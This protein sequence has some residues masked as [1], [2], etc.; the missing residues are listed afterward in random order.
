MNQSVECDFLLLKNNFGHDL[1]FVE[2]K[3]SIIPGKLKLI[4]KYL[5]LNISYIERYSTQ[6]HISSFK[7][8]PIFRTLRNNSN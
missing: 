2:F 4:R 1:S 8:S 6:K 3:D 7:K 5:P